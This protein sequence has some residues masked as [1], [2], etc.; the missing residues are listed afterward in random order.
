MMTFERG[1]DGSRPGSR[2]G[3][4]RQ[5][6]P[7]ARDPERPVPLSPS[8][9]RPSPFRLRPRVWIPVVGLIG[10]LIA[11]VAVAGVPSSQAGGPARFDAPA[12]AGPRAL[13]LSGLPPELNLRPEQ[14]AQMEEA[15]SELQRDRRQLREP[16]HFGPRRGPAWR[17]GGS[18]AGPP[19]DRERPG[20]GAGSGAGWGAPAAGQELPMA[21]F[22][23]SSARILDAEQF[24]TLTRFLDERREETRLARAGRAG[25][26]D[27]V[28]GRLGR[29]GAR[30]LDLS[31]EQRDRLRPAFERYGEGMKEN[32]D[33]LAA[34]TLTP[35]QA[36]DRAKA[37]RSTLEQQ[38]RGILSPEQWAK[39]EQLRDDR[40]DR[41]AERRTENPARRL[42]RRTGFLI[43]VLDL[44]EQ[45]ADDVRRLTT[46]SIPARRA[47]QERVASGAI[48]PEDAAYEIHRI[49]LDLAQRIRAVLT[50]E[51][52]R[53]FDAVK[54]LRPGGRSGPRGEGRWP[55]PRAGGRDRRR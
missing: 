46:E 41:R 10:G 40:R 7:D 20:R 12:G 6:A 14:R 23:E 34:G 47:V 29:F 9:S 13:Q 11:A 8:P 2:S 24:A 22:L 25:G 28:D 49:E 51:Q 44:N 36:R 21:R 18:A 31:E 53:R 19:R 43:R 4:F 16:R 33:G 27:R 38:A 3:A 55:G 45:Q 52:A 1:R 26:P 15:L 32:R 48:E 17:Q 42:D 30:Q 5:G 54:D 50:E 37:L 39:A 35:E